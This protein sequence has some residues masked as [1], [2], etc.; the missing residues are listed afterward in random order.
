MEA[1]TGCYAHYDQEEIP[2]ALLATMNLFR[3]GGQ[4]FGSGDGNLVP[5]AKRQLCG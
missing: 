2:K 3:R 5:R 1:L 4:T